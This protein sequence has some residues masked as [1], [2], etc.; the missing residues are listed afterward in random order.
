MIGKRAFSSGALDFYR[1]HPD[2]YSLQESDFD[3]SISLRD[4]YWL[5][6]TDDEKDREHGYLQCNKRKLTDGRQALVP[7]P[8][9]FKKVMGEHL[10]RWESFEIDQPQFDA[11]DNDP[12]YLN[13]VNQN[14]H[15]KFLDE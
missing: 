14:I 5:Q 8:L 6:L 3:V 12:A 7:W 4:K 9:D 11:P 2:R 15:G 13:A 10:E 1:K